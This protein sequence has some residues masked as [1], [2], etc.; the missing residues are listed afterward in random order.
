MTFANRISLT[1]IA[2][3]SRLYVLAEVTV[4]GVPTPTL[5]QLTDVVATPQTVVP[6]PGVPANL[7]GDPTQPP[8]QAWYDHGL[9]AEVVGANDRI[10]LGGSTVMPRNDAEGEWSA[11]L[12]CFETPSPPA[13]VAALTAP[14]G[15]A[16]RNNPPTGD[17][18]DVNGLIG[19]NVHADIHAIRLTGGVAPNRQVWVGCD[20]GVYVSGNS[21]RVNTFAARNAGLATLEPIFIDAH[22]TSSH[23]V[24]AG[25]QDNGTQVRTGDTVWEETFLGDG[26]GT[27]FHPIRTDI[28]VTQYT[29]GTWNGAPASDYLDPLTRSAGSAGATGR[30]G[31]AT[32]FYS[33]AATIADTATT[34]RVALGTNRVWVTDNLGDGTPLRWRTLPYPNGTQ[35]DTRP[36]GSDPVAQRAFGVPGF[37]NANFVNAAGNSTADQVIDMV[38]Q[39]ANDLLVIHRG[40]LVRYTNTNKA[41]G[42][43]NTTTWSLQNVA[44]PLALNTVMTAVATVPGGLDFYLTTLGDRNNTNTET[45]WFFDNAANTF[46]PTGFRRV[47]DYPGPPA[48]VAGPAR[49]GLRGRGRPDQRG[50]P[51][52][53]HRDRRVAGHAHRTG[54][55]DVRAVHERLAPGHRAGSRDLAGPGGRRHEPAAVAGRRPEPR[56]VGGRPRARP[57]AT[58][59]CP[60]P[61]ARRP[62]HAADPHGEPAPSPG[63]ARGTRVRKSGH[64]RT[65]GVAA[66]R[67]SGL[68]HD[69]PVGERAD[70]RPVDVPDRV[71]LVVPRLHR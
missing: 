68:P 62:P 16:R 24:G 27:V 54:R 50:E 64:R 28:I 33:G 31:A 67:A 48:V 63:R 3:T 18:A 13:A 56:R 34:G 20:G 70:L 9:A 46:R 26:G 69:D 19:N 4:A 49:P 43:W 32:A 6:V 25:L 36:G 11:S 35:R 12:F 14:T 65:P 61:R 40:G 44:I 38:W 30:E 7:F 5:W 39:S 59:L 29:N 21:G 2:G 1:N 15:I 37:V 51:V 42:T 45:L 71:P 17:G 47:L 58:H 10:Y 60:R 22:P 53:G 52:R 8:T 41:T 55:V 57:T 66:G 23:F